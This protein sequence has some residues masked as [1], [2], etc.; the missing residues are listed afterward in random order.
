MWCFSGKEEAEHLSV[1]GLWRLRRKAAAGEKNLGL[2]LKVEEMV[3]GFKMG[4]WDKEEEEEEGM[5]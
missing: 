1:L 3:L 2:G 5:S 4:L